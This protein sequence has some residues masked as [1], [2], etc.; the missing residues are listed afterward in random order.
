MSAAAASAAAADR[1]AGAAAR[2]SRPGPARRPRRPA[3]TAPRVR[4]R[5][6]AAGREAGPHPGRGGLRPR[7]AG[8]RRAER[9]PGRRLPHG[10]AGQG[11]DR[12][13][14][15]RPGRTACA[16]RPSPWRAP[17]RARWWTSSAPAATRLGHL[18][19]LHH[20]GLRGGRRGGQGG[21]ARQPGGQL[22]SAARPTC[23]RRWASASI[24]GP[25][26][27]PPASTRWAWASCWPRCTI[28]R[29][30]GW[31]A[32]GAPSGVRTVFNFLGP[33]TNPAGVRR[34]LLGVST[35]AASRRAG[36]RARP[37]GL[38]ARARGVRRPR[39]WTSSRSPGPN[40]AIEVDARGGAPRL[41][42]DPEDCGLD[43]HPLEDLAGGDAQANAAI[44]RDILGG[45]A[46]G[47]AGR[48]AH[49]RRRGSLCGR[50]GS[51]PREGVEL[52]R[53]SIDSG[54]A[55][56]RARRHDRG[57]Q[58]PGRG[59]RGGGRARPAAAAARRSGVNG[60]S[61]LDVIVPDVRR[62]LAERRP[63]RRW[64]T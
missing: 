41:R 52:A 25:R 51:V 18:Q 47:P 54:S 29:P 9:R 34:Q 61:Y 56:A 26:R 14:D 55:L 59:R 17:T 4:R 6:Q 44:T 23:W 12:R 39:A 21:Q 20:G 33:L 19:H 13:R 45:Q 37:H 40:R 28:R 62:R 24:W 60:R 1:D 32:S 31:P 50:R 7:P 48:G 42:I 64:P 49:E 15:R 8:E 2:R 22:A 16:A 36:R 27:W 11:R 63:A 10:P 43:R 3:G 58:P 57:D 5:P 30:A 38:R 53:V 46:G 35:P